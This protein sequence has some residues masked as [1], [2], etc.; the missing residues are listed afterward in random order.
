MRKPDGREI[1]RKTLAFHI[2]M[3]SGFAEKLTVDYGISQI[4]G[5]KMG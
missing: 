2:L 5:T 1:I 3:S 4:S